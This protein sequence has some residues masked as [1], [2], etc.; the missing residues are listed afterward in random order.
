MSHARVALTSCCTPDSQHSDYNSRYDERP[1]QTAARQSSEWN[2]NHPQA[3]NGVDPL[4]P[5]TLVSLGVDNLDHPAHLQ[6]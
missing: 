3:K 2:C 1:H 6:K 4:L 5:H